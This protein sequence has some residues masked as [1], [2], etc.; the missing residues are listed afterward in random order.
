MLDELERKRAEVIKKAEEYKRRRTEL[1]AEASK[2]ADLRDEL[3]GR[4]REEVEKAKIFKKKR[5]EYEALIEAN[6]A[7]RGELNRKASKY[8]SMVEK[9]RKKNDMHSIRTFEGLRTRIDELELKQQ[10][11]V[12]SKDEE[13][14]LVA[15]IAELRKELVLMQK[16]WEKDQKLKEL[17]LSAQKYRE[18]A[19]KYHEEVLSHV[20]LSHECHDKMVESFKEADRVHRKADD[21]H[22]QFLEA[23]EKADD[24]HR[25]YLT[26]IRDVEDFNHVITGLRRKIEEDWGFKERVEARKAAKSIYERFRDGEKLSTDDLLALQKTE[27]LLK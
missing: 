21:A 7:N 5:E 27:M 15:K 9:L 25:Q 13:R 12:L 2:W 22:R 11:E 20:K 8:Y 4:I 26:Y 17:L 19:D 23:Q 1:N 18:E 16:E 10:V 6:K 14:K 3:N 24:A